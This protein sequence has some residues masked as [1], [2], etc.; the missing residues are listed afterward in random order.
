MIKFKQ[1]DKEDYKLSD[2]DM[3]AFEDAQ[4]ASWKKFKSLTKF[5]NAVKL[6]VRNK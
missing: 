3:K 2:E 1:W 4:K 5:E 6:K